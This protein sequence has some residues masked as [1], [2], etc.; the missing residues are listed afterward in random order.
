VSQ[1]LQ[2]STL[3]A[4][5][6]DGEEHALSPKIQGLVSDI[7]KLTLLE[8]AE[9]SGALKKALNLPDAPVAMMAGPGAFAAAPAEVCHF[10]MMKR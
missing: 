6:P 3:V 2:Q 7:S 4:P 1:R 10:S 8:V 5:V 9:L